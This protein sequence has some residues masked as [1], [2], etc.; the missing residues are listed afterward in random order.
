MACQD[1]GAT[2]RPIFDGVCSMCYCTSL[3]DPYLFEIRMLFFESTDFDTYDT[4]TV[5]RTIRRSDITYPFKEFLTE[6]ENKCRWV[7]VRH[8]DRPFV[9]KRR[10]IQNCLSNFIYHHVWDNA[11]Q[12]RRTLYKFCTMARRGL[13]E[14]YLN[15]EESAI[16]TEI[17]KRTL[18]FRH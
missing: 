16:L 12:E 14:G 17:A 10:W 8:P 7:P 5:I 6:F 4:E 9:L 1:C 15:Q 13:Q 3:N 18:V 11:A 2:Q